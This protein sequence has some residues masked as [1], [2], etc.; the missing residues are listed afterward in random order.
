V[1]HLVV[2][3]GDHVSRGVVR[4][5]EPWASAARR[6]V[7]ASHH[8]PEPLD[9]SAD[10]QRW[11]VDRDVRVALRAATRADLDDLVA[12]RSDPEVKRWWSAGEIRSDEQ[13]AETYGR[14]IDGLSPTRLWLVEVNGRSAGFVQDYRIGDY[15]EYAVLGP[16]PDAV[17]VD[18]A[19]GAPQ[20]RGTGLGPRVLWA[21]MQ[22][23]RR[24]RPDAATYF[25][26]PD[27]RNAASRRILVKAGFVE[28]LWFD[29]P[30]PDGTTTTVVGH[31]LDVGRVVGPMH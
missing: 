17:G 20:W 7:G 15:P 13:I 10:P 27:H 2:Q 8:D 5:G 14:R 26:A 29:E 28:G 6:T 18:Y 30:Q 12:W 31:T 21:W 1:V 16:D 11:V 25:A 4:D 9:L 19:I 24:T 22:K 3:D 23:A